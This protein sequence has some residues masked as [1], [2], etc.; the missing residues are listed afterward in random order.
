M[1]KVTHQDFATSFGTDIDDLPLDLIKGLDFSYAIPKDEERD[2]ILLKILKGI[3]SDDKL[4]GTPERQ[5]IWEEGWKEN[6]DNFTKTEDLKSLTPK[7]YVVKNK[8]Q[9]NVKRF[10]RKLIIPSDSDFELNYFTVFRIWLFKKYLKNVESIYEFGCGSGFNLMLFAQFF[11]DKQFYGLDYTQASQKIINKIAE[12]RNWNMKGLF[13]DMF[14]PD[15][16]IN[17]SPNSGVLTVASIEQLASNFEPF[18]QYLLKNKP[19]VC[20]HIEPIIEL[21]DENNL[22][23]YLAI[24]FHRRRGYSEGFLTRLR[25]LESEGKIEI[26]KVKRLFL[27][28]LYNEGYSYIIW[29][30]R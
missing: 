4:I 12:I 27:G 6:L 20:V 11:P 15:E 10:N 14:S 9:S 19:K 5:D 21:Y 18:L 8:E 30:I 7:Y 13:F 26:L 24:K 22:L 2:K 25:K 17:I 1:H 16:Q 28:G 23:D 3:E 29:R